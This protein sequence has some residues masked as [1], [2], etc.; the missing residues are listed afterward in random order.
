MFQ[1]FE[2]IP[3]PNIQVKTPTLFIQDKFLCKDGFILYRA[4]MKAVRNLSS[5]GVSIL[6]GER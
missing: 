6:V 4:F 2:K 1:A 3:H 5:E